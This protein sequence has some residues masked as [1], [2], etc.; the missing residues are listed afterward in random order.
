MTSLPF[1]PLRLS[2]ATTAKHPPGGNPP[3]G[4]LST[5]PLK[6][7]KTIPHVIGFSGNAPGQHLI[8]DNN[9][10]ERRSR[11]FEEF[12]PNE[13]QTQMMRDSR[14]L[15]KTGGLLSN[16]S[17]IAAGG[18]QGSEHLYNCPSDSAQHPDM[19]MT[20]QINIQWDYLS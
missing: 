15:A 6:F 10:T 14:E 5:P 3:Q 16:E 20:R 17:K 12:C 13:S 4:P 8:G 1:P 2:S 19:G 9:R 7:P 11:R 18:S